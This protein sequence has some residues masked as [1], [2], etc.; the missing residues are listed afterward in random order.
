MIWW[1]ARFLHAS[2]YYYARR[3][4][5]PPLV[6][7]I[8]CYIVSKR[9]RYDIADIAI[10]F[11]IILLFAEHISCRDMMILCLWLHSEAAASREKISSPREIKIWY[12]WWYMIYYASFA[13]LS[14]YYICLFAA[15]HD[16]FHAAIHA[17]RYERL[18]LEINAFA[19]SRCAALS[20]KMMPLLAFKE[21]DI[22]YDIY[23]DTP[24][25]RDMP[26]SY[27]YYCHIHAM[28]FSRHAA[29]SSRHIFVE[30]IW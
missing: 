11:H 6:H 30:H 8:I 25:L 1:Y 7:I 29:F 20:P 12:I 16:I 18:L 23:A 15:S 14:Y 19:I 2:R 10:L 22:I 28:I 26:F 13:S 4:F 21:R 5:T 17:A 24:P 9:L 27:F 3:A